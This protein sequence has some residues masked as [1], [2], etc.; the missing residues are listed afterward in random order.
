MEG[1]YTGR[2]VKQLEDRIVVD[3]SRKP[4]SR[5]RRADTS[6]L[7]SPIAIRVYATLVYQLNWVEKEFR[8]EFAGAGS[9]L[10]G[11]VANSTIA[12]CRGKPRHCAAEENH[13]SE[14]HD[15]V[16]SSRL[17]PVTVRNLVTHL[18]NELRLRG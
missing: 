11:N 1:D 15:T 9:L 8:P 6:A 13:K 14:A 7:P 18:T 4:A 5:R 12:H 17:W 10:S 16:L 2:H 3:Q